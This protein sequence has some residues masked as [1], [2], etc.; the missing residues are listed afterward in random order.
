MP[1]P[2][3]EIDTVNSIC[4]TPSPGN[5]HLPEGLADIFLLL[6][7][8]CVGVYVS[9]KHLLEGEIRNLIQFIP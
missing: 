2:V 5:R 9:E 1:H 7:D 6:I 4:A 3:S 8:M